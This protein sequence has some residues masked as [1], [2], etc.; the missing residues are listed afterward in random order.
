MPRGGCGHCGAFLRSKDMA[1][2]LRE[3]VRAMNSYYSSRIEGQSTHP[4]NVDSALER[5]IGGTRHLSKAA[6]RPGLHGSRA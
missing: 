2:V 4:K 1:R 5:F 6:H 3:F